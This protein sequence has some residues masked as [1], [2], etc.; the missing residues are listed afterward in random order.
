M[1]SGST[2]SSQNATDSVG[3]AQADYKRRRFLPV[4]RLSV[5]ILIGVLLAGLNIGR[6]KHRQALA[7][8][9]PRVWTAASH[10]NITSRQSYLHA[11]GAHLEDARG[12]PFSIRAINWSG[13]ETPQQ[14]LGG[15]K[16]VDYRSILQRI[17]ADGFN[18]IR[19]PFS[20]EMVEEPIIPLIGV[21]KVGGYT[22][23]ED[24]VGLSSLEILDR[25]VDKAASLD[26]KVILDNHRSES[27][28]SAEANGLWFT[29]RFTEAA[30]IDDWIMLAQRYRNSPAVIGADLRNEPHNALSGGACWGC[31]GPHDWR[32]A[33]ER[34]GNQVLS[35]NPN[36][37]II[38]E[39][40]DSAQG[41]TT[42]WG[43]NLAGVRSA[44]VN[45]SRP[46]QLVYST[47]VYGPTEYKQPWF[48]EKT[49][50]AQLWSQWDRQWGFIS[51]ADVAP[52]LVGEFGM[53][54]HEKEAEAT[55]PGSE[56][57]W[58]ASLLSYFSLHPNL[59]WAYWSLNT[60]DP[61]GWLGQG[62]SAASYDNWRNSSL[63]LVISDKT[64]G[65]AVAKDERE[66]K[67][68]SVGQAIVAGAPT[69]LNGTQRG[70][71][72]ALKI[73]TLTGVP[74]SGAHPRWIGDS[75]IDTAI[76]TEIELATSRALASH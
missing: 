28:S 36:L 43:G 34:A 37:L 63:R 35:T 26:L 5:L 57:Q 33:A 52:V 38:V 70:R 6:T 76:K 50:A 4:L 58:F 62:Y 47:H 74:G 55:T 42:W 19:I 75:S 24:L 13:L 3:R 15:L 54:E 12:L 2:P 20:N 31:E 23:N 7:D 11:V 27:G 68:Y 56:G 46:S 51:N 45:L 44:P 61:Y 18:V 69:T 65:S 16:T 66:V 21:P 30:W 64:E 8:Q 9:E 25:V 32:L 14:C 59:G 73:G 39:G 41:Q 17:K 22:V 48:T 29:N 72:S 67:G 1:R 10:R 53:P 71:P 40:T 49:T 60:E